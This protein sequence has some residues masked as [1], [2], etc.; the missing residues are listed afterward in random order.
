MTWDSGSGSLHKSAIPTSVPSVSSKIGGSPR[1][2]YRLVGITYGIT[3]L[4]FWNLTDWDIVGDFQCRGFGIQKRTWPAASMGTSDSTWVLL[5]ETAWPRNRCGQVTTIVGAYKGW[6]HKN[7]WFRD[8]PDDVPPFV[9]TFI[10]VW[11]VIYCTVQFCNAMEWN[12]MRCTAMQC[13]VSMY[14]C[15]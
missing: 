11:N 13:N 12:G 8:V 6:S 9:E 4:I 1:K 10:Y 3:N 2:I 7:G 5:P 14:V 15:M